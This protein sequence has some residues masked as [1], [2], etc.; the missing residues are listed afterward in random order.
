MNAISYVAV[1]FVLSAF[2]APAPAI[3]EGLIVEKTIV[4][5]TVPCKIDLGGHAYERVN[6]RRYDYVFVLVGEND[7]GELKRIEMDV[8]QDKYNYYDV[9]DTY[10]VNP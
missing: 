7:E 10:I 8:S 2:L 4:E 9:G 1:L 6:A 3:N 5:S